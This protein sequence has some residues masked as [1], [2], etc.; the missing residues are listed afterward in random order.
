MEQTGHAM[1]QRSD[2]A[3]Q[4][5][6]ETEQTE[7]MSRHLMTLT[8]TN[9]NQIEQMEAEFKQSPIY[10]DTSLDRITALKE[11]SQERSFFRAKQ[12]RPRAD[13]RNHFIHQRNDIRMISPDLFPSMHL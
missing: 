2:C 5:F 7:K 6:A 9:G 12:T 1:S 11:G 13:D 4:V 3:H 8:H 10:V